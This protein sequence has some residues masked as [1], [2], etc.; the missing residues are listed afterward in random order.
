[1]DSKVNAICLALT[2]RLEELIACGLSKI[3]MRSSGLERYHMAKILGLSS[4][5]WDRIVQFSGLFYPDKRIKTISWQQLL[6]FSIEFRSFKTD[7]CK[8]KWF[9][10][11]S[12]IVP[13]VNS[14]QRSSRGHSI[15]LVEET[16]LSAYE[17]CN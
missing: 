13:D 8:T 9:R 6:G 12:R 10:F 1:M 4:E 5:D 16:A 15:C 11:I 7:G 14:G 17:G 2:H 3:W